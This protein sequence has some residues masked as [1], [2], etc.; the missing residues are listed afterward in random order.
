MSDLTDFQPSTLLAEV[1]D[2]VIATWS[3]QKRADFCQTFEQRTIAARYI[4][5]ETAKQITDSAERRHFISAKHYR[6]IVKGFPHPD[7]DRSF[8]N[9]YFIQHFFSNLRHASVGNSRHAIGDR[10]PSQLNMIAKERA[11]QV[12]QALPPIAKVVAIIDA[13]TAR[14]LD[15]KDKL[16]ADGEKLRLRLDDVCGVIRMSD[17]EYQDMTVRQFRD[18]VIERDNR[19]QDLIEQMNVLTVEGQQLEEEIAKKLFAGLPGVSEA[20]VDVIRTHIEQAISL[21]TVNRRVAE[22]VKFGD[23]ATAVELLRRFEKDEVEVST[24]VAASFQ[25][26]LDALKVSVKTKKKAKAKSDLRLL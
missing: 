1:D 8:R 19:R 3:E 20:V 13:E 6:D 14:K 5:I 10:D 25:A 12:L 11:K 2:A 15:R 22:Q 26:A 16:Q 18:L 24:K 21:E 9:D 4:L 17:D 23:S 7:R